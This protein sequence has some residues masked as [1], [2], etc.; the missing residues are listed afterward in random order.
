[1]AK[2]K[3]PVHR[4]QMTEGDGKFEPKINVKY[5][6]RSFPTVRNLYNDGKFII[7]LCDFLKTATL[8]FFIQVSTFLRYFQTE[9]FWFYIQNQRYTLLW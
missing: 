2:Q 1:M 7:Y 4:I 9:S 5:P 3:E 6:Y 8:Q